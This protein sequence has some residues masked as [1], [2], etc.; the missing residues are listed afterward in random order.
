LPGAL[1]RAD[2]ASVTGDNFFVAT[3]TGN[4]GIA[5]RHPASAIDVS[6]G[7]VKGIERR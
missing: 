6:A 2:S 4:L 7:E 1:V 3:E 5:T